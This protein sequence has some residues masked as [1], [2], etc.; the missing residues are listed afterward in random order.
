MKGYGVVEI[1]YQKSPRSLTKER[2]EG[3]SEEVK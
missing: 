2:K 1:G 3:E